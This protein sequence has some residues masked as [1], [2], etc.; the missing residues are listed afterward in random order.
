[1]A[2]KFQKLIDAMPPQRRAR[3]D[4]SVERLLADLHLYEL[5]RGLEV[6]QQTLAR[7]LKTDQA[8]ISRLEQRADLLVS[9]LR[10]Y[11]EA[12]G[13]RLEIVASFP[14]GGAVAIKNFRDL[15]TRKTA[16]KRRVGASQ[17]A[18]KSRAQVA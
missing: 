3:S 14:E 12:L 7:R 18:R 15:S 6:S 9:T 4:A 16:P 10:R 8:Q 11:V 2:R 17:K 5:R 1:M 13:G